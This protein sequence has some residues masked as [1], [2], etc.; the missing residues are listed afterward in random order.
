MRTAV[1]VKP[2]Q[3][4]ADLWQL[5]YATLRRAKKLVQS[6]HK[7]VSH[8]Q[9]TANDV[10]NWVFAGNAAA[11]NLAGHVFQQSCPLMHAWTQ[12]TDDLQQLACFREKVHQVILA[13]GRKAILHNVQTTNTDKP[14]PTPRLHTSQIQEVL[15]PLLAK[16]D[17]P[18][19]YQFPGCEKILHWLNHLICSDQEPRP[20]SWFELNLLY[21]HQTGD[22]G[23][24]Y[25]KKRKQWLHHDAAE[26]GDF[27]K[28]ANHMS[29][30]IQGCVFQAEGRCQAY[31]LLSSSP[32]ITFWCQCVHARLSSE[33]T[34]LINMLL[35]EQ[36]PRFNCVAA[37]R[38]IG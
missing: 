38:T 1:W 18:R 26:L 9:P 6:V 27:N 35:Q 33:D 16:S 29:R 30:Y 13:V 17:L 15:I 28:R 10:D 22:K 36:Q 19:K 7:V 11:D 14:P 32:H 8:Q 4:D 23:V 24:V 3:R 5:L 25:L 20:V 2:N 12:L 37:F 34:A 21:E 31:N